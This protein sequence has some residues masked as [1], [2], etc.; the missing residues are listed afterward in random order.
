M[1]NI[2]HDLY[3]A[4]VDCGKRK[5]EMSISIIKKDGYYLIKPS[6]GVAFL[7]ILEM[8][9]KL[10]GSD[11]YKGKHG[12]W[13]FQE[14]P[15]DIEFED[16]NRIKQLIIEA[17]PE[18]TPYSKIALVSY[19]ALQAQFAAAFMDVADSLP[20]EFMFFSEVD[21]AEKWIKT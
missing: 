14:G 20:F 4:R 2:N 15:F 13:H 9:L 7:E 12:I 10:S 5:Q 6:K 19:S 21:S 8:I 1:I 17:Y 3:K 16:I 11:K 18:D